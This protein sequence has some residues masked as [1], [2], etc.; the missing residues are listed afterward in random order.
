MLDPNVEV[1]T[2]EGGTGTS[3]GGTTTTTTNSTSSPGNTTQD[4]SVLTLAKTLFGKATDANV[5]FSLTVNPT[6]PKTD[7]TRYNEETNSL[8]AYI[9]GKWI[10]IK[11]I[12]SPNPQKIDISKFSAKEIQEYLSTGKPFPKEPAQQIVMTKVSASNNTTATKTKWWL[13]VAIASVVGVSLWA[14]WKYAKKQ[15]SKS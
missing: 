9:A 12:L 13:Y 2:E 11:V 14:V 10:K 15:S 7:N 6:I 8:E 5:V 3:N 4:S 1:P